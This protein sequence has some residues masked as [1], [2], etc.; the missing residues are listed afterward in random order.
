MRKNIT[1]I[2]IVIILF[3]GC[4]REPRY[5]KKRQLKGSISISGAFALYPMA[6]LWAE[7]FMKIYPDVEID[8][9]AGGAGKGMADVLNGMVDLGMVSR[10]INLAEYKKG[11]WNIAVVKDAVLPTISSKNPFIDSLKKKGVTRE[12]LKLIFIEGTI[13]DWGIIANNSKKHGA[14]H[15]FTR[16]DACGAGEMWGKYLGFNQEAIQGVGVYGDPGMA[17]AVRNEPSSIGYNNVIYAYD[18]VTRKFYDGIQVLPIDINNNGKIDSYEN[19][20]DNLDSLN[21][22]IRENKYPSP[23]G[24]ELYFVSKGKPKKNV[25]KEFLKWILTDGQKYV[26]KTGY[27]ELAEKN[28]LD[29]LAKIKFNLRRSFHLINTNNKEK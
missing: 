28:R 21:E 3:A 8:I 20:Y 16:S 6:V 29:E 5:H 11:A 13:N 24:R 23:P 10:E 15:V 1:L 17:E 9:S 19:F 2:L 18:L 27:V 7:E 25:V 14:I 12:Q 4:S 22:A 26:R